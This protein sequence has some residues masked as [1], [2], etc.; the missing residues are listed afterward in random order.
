[1]RR[2]ARRLTSSR[3]RDC[4]VGLAQS[5]YI[6]YAV[7]RHCHRVSRLFDCLYQ[8]GFLLGRNPAENCVFRSNL[9]NRFFVQTFETYIIF[10][11]FHTH[12][13]G[14]VANGQRIVAAYYLCAYAVF[15]KPIDC[16]YRV[17][18]Y[19]VLNHNQRNR[20]AHDGQFYFLVLFG[21]NYAGRLRQ[22]QHSETLFG[23]FPDQ[24]INPLIFR[25]EHKFGRAEKKGAF[26]FK[27]YRGQLA[28]GGKRNDC[29]MFKHAFGAEMLF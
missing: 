21:I 26:L 16:F 20:T 8:N 2:V 10:R 7:P 15:L 12:L 3:K 4:T 23:I 1:M 19:M 29:R 22:Q 25:V 24:R 5:K 6:V 28:R 11:V 9:G 18:A 27:G 13:G 14:D 17:V